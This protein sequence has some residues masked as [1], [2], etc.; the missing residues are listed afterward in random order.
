MEAGVTGAVATKAVAV[1]RVAG[2]GVRWGGREGR[3]GLLGALPVA[4]A[5]PLA[6]DDDLAGLTGCHGPAAHPE[7]Q[8][9]HPRRRPAGGQ[10]P[11]AVLVTR[12][13]DVL[14]DDAHL[15]GRVVVDDHAAKREVAARE[16]EVAP[17]DRLATQVDGADAR[18]GARPWR[19]LGQEPEDRRDAVETG[20]PLVAVSTP[21][22]PPGRD[23]A[24]RT[25]RGSRRGAACRRCPC[26][27]R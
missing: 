24:R 11:V 25:C 18:V 5:E 22:G 10:E 13:R 7:Q 23:V 16:T 8:E 20:D 19:V 26:S 14:G 17:E 6:P 27:R 1:G 21:A 9:L 2:R 15:G 3:G 4:G 12:L